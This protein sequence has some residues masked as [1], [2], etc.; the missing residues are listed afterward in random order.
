MARDCGRAV[1]AE[2]RAAGVPRSPVVVPVLPVVRVH[3]VQVSLGRAATPTLSTPWL[4]SASTE[5]RR[6]PRLRPDPAL[7]PAEQ[8]T[9][10]RRGPIRTAS[11]VPPGGLSASAR[12]IHRLVGGATESRRLTSRFACEVHLPIRPAS[13]G[14]SHTSWPTG[15]RSPQGVGGCRMERLCSPRAKHIGAA[16]PGPA[17]RQH[18]GRRRSSTGDVAAARSRGASSLADASSLAVIQRGGRSANPPRPL[19]HLLP[20]GNGGHGGRV[21]HPRGPTT[22]RPPDQRRDVDRHA[23]YRAGRRTG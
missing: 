17:G 22:G 14:E 13:G 15:C 4:R 9:R 18:T 10:T 2:S 19:P 6:S 7:L 21:G 5:T 11:G 3:A 23:V 20:S 12:A 1:F 16:R 8:A